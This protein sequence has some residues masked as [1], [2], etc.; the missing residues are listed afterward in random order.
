MMG[1]QTEWNIWMG[2]SA[3]TGRGEVYTPK[4]MF[5][6]SV[7]PLFPLLHQFEGKRG[8]GKCRGGQG[9]HGHFFYGGGHLVTLEHDLSA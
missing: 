9:G 2:R 6:S 4:P 8:D 3:R 1:L 7:R 5:A